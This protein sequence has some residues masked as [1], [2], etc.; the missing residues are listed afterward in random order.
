ML[1]KLVPYCV[2]TTINYCFVIQMSGKSVWQGE[3]RD[4]L[5]EMAALYGKHED[6]FDY[7][8]APARGW[9]EGKRDFSARVTYYRWHSFEKFNKNKKPDDYSL[10]H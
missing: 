5:E 9:Q 1:K 4:D 6:A 3:Y 10:I 2:L 7:D 8:K